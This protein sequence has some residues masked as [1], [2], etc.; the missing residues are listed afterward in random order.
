MPLSEHE[1]RALEEIARHLSEEDPKFVA[2]VSNQSPVRVHLRRLRWAAVGFVVGLVL[3]LGLTF[4][5]L[6]GL[7]G[8]GLMLASVIAAAGAVRKL[9]G[10]GSRVMDELRRAFGREERD[11]SL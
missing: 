3:L 11:E 4:H 9:T 5:F 7:V 2:T 1:E 10:G 6:F 8:F